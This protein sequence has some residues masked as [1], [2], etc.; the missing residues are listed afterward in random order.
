MK[1]AIN[2]ARLHNHE[3]QD[4]KPPEI[5]M[6]AKVVDEIRASAQDKQPAPDHQI[7]LNRVLLSL[8]VRHVFSLPTI[9]Y[10]RSKSTKMNNSSPGRPPRAPRDRSS[11]AADAP[12]QKRMISTNMKRPAGLSKTYFRDPNRK[13]ASPSIAV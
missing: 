5:S 11:D 9:D 8:F 4:Q 2:Q 10:Q 7:K 6:N 3:Q 12:P 1:T 13:T